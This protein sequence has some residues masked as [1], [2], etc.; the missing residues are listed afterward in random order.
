L[1]PG[2]EPQTQTLATQYAGSQV[3]TAATHPAGGAL[4]QL[5]DGQLL[6]YSCY[7]AQICQM[8]QAA[9]FPAACKTMLVLPDAPLPAAAAAAGCNG[10]IV[11]SSSSSVSAERAARAA[12]AAPAIGL[13]AGGQ[14]LWGSR[15]VADGVASV[16]VR[17][18]GAGV[19]A[20]AGDP[21]GAAVCGDGGA[22]AELH[23]RPG[24]ALRG[25]D[26]FISRHDKGKGG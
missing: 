24:E 25:V 8:P 19:R 22:A 21:P 15:V 1:Y 3:L 9:S 4:L 11:S 20:A 13:S 17:G 12:A 7:N 26:G 16:A 6:Y 14:V 23:A 18:A 2:P 10:G 5:Q